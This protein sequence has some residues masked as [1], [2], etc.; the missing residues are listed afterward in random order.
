MVAPYEVTRWRVGGLGSAGSELGE[1]Q[2]D[3]YGVVQDLSHGP[4]RTGRGEGELRRLDLTTD[5]CLQF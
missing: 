5:S 3:P 2:R 1:F 4:A